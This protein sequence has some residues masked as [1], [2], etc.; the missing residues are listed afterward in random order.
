MSSQKLYRIDKFDVPA[1]ARDEF[2]ARLRIID[3]LLGAIDGCESHRIF[4][5]RAGGGDAAIVT[6]AQWRDEA[7]IGKAQATVAAEYARTGFDPRAF[8]TALGVRGDLGVY[9]ELE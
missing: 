5:R 4:E 1:A 6:V 3:R 8:M 2:L 9:R 7:A